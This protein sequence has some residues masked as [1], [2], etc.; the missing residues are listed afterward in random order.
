MELS[1]AGIM[2]QCC[3]R[4]V[5]LLSLIFSLYVGDLLPVLIKLSF[6]VRNYWLSRPSVCGLQMLHLKRAMKRKCNLVRKNCNVLET[7]TLTSSLT[8]N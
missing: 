5:L 7:I 2:V 3:G 4:R 6:I 8:S 1:R